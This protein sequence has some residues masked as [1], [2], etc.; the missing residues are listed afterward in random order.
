MDALGLVPQAIKHEVEAREADGAWV[1]V[2]ESRGRGVVPQSDDSLHSTAAAHVQDAVH[3]GTGSTVHQGE[4]ILGDVHHRLHVLGRVGLLKVCGQDEVLLHRPERDVGRHKEGSAAVRELIHLLDG[5]IGLHDAA[6]VAVERGDDPQLKQDTGE[7][8]AQ[9]GAQAGEGQ[10]P[11]QQE[12]AQQVH[13]V[14][15]DLHRFLH[16]V[17][18][19]WFLDVLEKPRLQDVCASLH[20]DKLR[21][22]RGLARG[23]DHLGVVLVLQHDLPEVAESLRAAT[24][25]EVHPLHDVPVTWG[26]QLCDVPVEEGQPRI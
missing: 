7:L 1:H 6:G 9:Q 12:D 16:G 25:G 20:E 22:R 24:A 5:L 19:V 23:H 13:E 11:V 8:G 26:L 10:H 4:G 14:H 21:H 15:W 2:H 3:L 17:H 18:R